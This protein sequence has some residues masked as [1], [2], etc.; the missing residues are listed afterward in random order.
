MKIAPE[1]KIVRSILLNQLALNANEDLY[2]SAPLM[3]KR[4]LK[5]TFKR[6][7]DELIKSE[8]DYD[9]LF[10]QQE[11]ATVSSYEVIRQFT[12]IASKIQIWDMVDAGAILEAFLKDKKSML[13]IANKINRQNLNQKHSRV[14]KQT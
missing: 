5:Y 4:K 3:Y 12:D 11:E 9:I 7:I 1:Q 6:Y 8:K 10:E 2:F 13:G 14:E